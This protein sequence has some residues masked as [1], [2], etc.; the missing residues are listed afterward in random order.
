MKNKPK[1]EQTAKVSKYPQGYFKDKPCKL[2]STTFSPK[3]PSEHYCSDKCKDTALFDCY[4]Y[5]NYGITYNYYIH[6]YKEQEGK[7]AICNTTGAIRALFNESTLNLVVD[8]DHRTGEVRGL[9]CHTCNSALGQFK[10]SKTLLL[11]AIAYLETPLVLP[12]TE[13]VAKKKIIVRNTNISTEKTL[14]ILI[15]FLDN[16]LTRKQ[17]AEKY[18]LTEARIRGIIE[19]TTQHSKQV[20]K[21]YNL[22]KESQT[23]IPNGSTSQANGDGSGL[24]L[25]KED[26]IVSSV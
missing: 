12:K 13:E 26:D 17:L 10:D 11:N 24:L 9:L 23:T 16:N 18:N 8:H 1:S 3:A 7:C 14:N 5:R 6:L 2:C 22:I 15:D 4:L 21:H 25:E 20:F 19:L